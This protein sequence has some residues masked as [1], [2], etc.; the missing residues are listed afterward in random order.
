MND[1]RIIEY[2]RARGSTDVPAG[3]VGSV[4]TAVDAAPAGRALFS[5]LL[6]AAVAAGVVA[7]VAVL[8]LVLGPGRNVG[9]A[10]SPS[11]T[12]SAGATLGE[13]R[14]AVTDATERLAD[15]AGVQGAQTAWIE[16]Y[17]ESATWFDWRPSGDQVVVTRSDIDVQAPWWTDPDGEPLSFGE[18]IQT[19][20][21]VIADG[22][23][24]WTE[25]GSWVVPDD[26]TPPRGPLAYG[27]GLLTAEIPALAPT[28]EAAETV[29][30][31]RDLDDGGQ[32]WVLEGSWDGGTWVSEW[33]I[34]LD[35]ALVSWASEGVGVTMYPS[36]NFGTASR[37]F[38]I[39]FTSI[40]EP[41][42]IQAPE[43][44]TP[45]PAEYGLP[46][47]LPLGLGSGQIG[48][49]SSSEQVD[50]CEDESG[51][52]RVEV[53]VGWWTNVA[54]DDPEVGEL[55][56]CQFFAPE[57]FDSTTATRERPTPEGVALTIMLL[58]GGC[59]GYI[60]PTIETRGVTV[61]GWQA[62]A[63]ELAQGKLETNPPG[64]YQ[65]V[66]DLTP[67]V[68]CE[69]GNGEL[70]VARTGVDLSGTYEENKVILDEMM[71]TMEITAP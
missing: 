48:A 34:S 50:D 4:M 60:N 49:T 28:V 46:D 27:I 52:Y 63:I 20:M 64:Q 13:L 37:R 30:T 43:S 56:A 55:A 26:R 62:T 53:P 54:H 8:A 7:V 44:P 21:D 6:P 3:F 41:A 71:Q 68:P 47:D 59:L 29:A 23:W 5:W 14:A 9:P 33:H 38:V 40:D 22:S 36:D 66:I 58:D 11:A 39:E 24:Y 12:P 42:P 35:G 1:E 65:Y 25:A 67:G 61:D 17:V 10:P 16:E 19:E 18:R 2:L 32:L 31:R 57:P 15:A 70:I 45:D 69:T 51:T